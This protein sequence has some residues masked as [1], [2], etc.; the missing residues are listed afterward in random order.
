MAM[1][2]QGCNLLYKL[3]SA[4]P[5]MFF[6]RYSESSAALIRKQMTA[7]T[8]VTIDMVAAGFI[9]VSAY[10]L[11]WPFW[12]GTVTISLQTLLDF[13]PFTRTVCESVISHRTPK[14]LGPISAA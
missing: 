7:P 5:S 12:L 8:E 4:W 1:P 2:Q 14:R 6:I 11:P 3:Y 13:T 10:A 9:P